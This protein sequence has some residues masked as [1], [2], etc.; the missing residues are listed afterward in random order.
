SAI[1]ANV[2]D[3]RATV[4]TVDSAWEKLDSMTNAIFNIDQL[5][6]RRYLIIFCSEKARFYYR[7]FD[8]CFYTSITSKQVQIKLHKS[9]SY[10]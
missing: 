1:I 5:R 10:I 4:I 7:A 6:D 9:F 3:E 2:R 8:I